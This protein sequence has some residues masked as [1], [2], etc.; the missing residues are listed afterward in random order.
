MTDQMGI[1]EQSLVTEV[2]YGQLLELEL[3]I[4]GETKAIGSGDDETAAELEGG[5]GIDVHSANES[6]C[7]QQELQ[8]LSR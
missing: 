7:T 6:C 4:R 3:E 8:Y 2:N 1:M 5:T